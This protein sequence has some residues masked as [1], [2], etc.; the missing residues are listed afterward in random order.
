MTFQIFHRTFQIFHY[1][2]FRSSV[3]SRPNSMGGRL[4]ATQGEAKG[5]CCWLP[6]GDNKTGRE[7]YYNIYIYIYIDIYS[8]IHMS[9]W[10]SRFPYRLCLYSIEEIDLNN[11]TSILHSRHQIYVH[12]YIYI[13]THH[14]S[15]YIY[16]YICNIYIYT[17]IYTSYT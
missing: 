10:Y 6:S 1:W 15:V 17:W 2:S 12:I 8:G 9:T 5:R 4:T 11:H 16:I 13:Y 3:A 7:W 14:I